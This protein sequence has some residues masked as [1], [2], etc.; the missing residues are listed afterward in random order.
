MVTPLAENVW[1]YDLGGVNAYLVDDDGTLTLVDTGM[2]WHRN[3]L[4]AGLHDAGFEPADLDRILLTHYDVDHVGGLAV[5]NDV[6]L[7]IYV[8][9]TDAPY[10]TG[11]RK[12]TLSNHKGIIQRL[13]RPFASVPDNPVEPLADGD[14]VGSFT[15]YETPGHTPGHVCYI[16]E[17]LETAFL[18]DLVVERGDGRL[19]PSLWIMNY[20]TGDV[21]RS[22]RTLAER[23]PAFEVAG[24]GHGVPFKTGGSE[25][26]ADVVERV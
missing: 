6:D 12:A 20:D 24:M 22:I 5:F 14:T 15:V 17:T 8:G 26:L 18:G 9:A 1:W 11:E 23:A 13:G 10:V 4:V 21:N 19:Y 2:K 3:T 16:S 7:T 25:R